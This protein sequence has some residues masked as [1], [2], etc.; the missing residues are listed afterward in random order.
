VLDVSAA[1]W[2][3]PYPESKENW[4]LIVQLCRFKY[5]Q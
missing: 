1:S 3:D 4:I 5:V 2:I